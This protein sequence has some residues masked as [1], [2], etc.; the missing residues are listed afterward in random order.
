MNDELL[1]PLSVLALDL[2]IAAAAL[3]DQLA[4]RV[5]IDDLGRSAIDRPTARRLIAEHHATVEARAQARAAAVAE[6]RQATNAPNPTRERV[7]ALQAR[8]RA[9]GVDALSGV[10]LAL[11][12]GGDAKLAAAGRRW[13]DYANAERDGSFGTYHR[14]IPTRAEG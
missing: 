5:L 11:A 13:D 7:R 9:A 6:R 4:D 2:D 10:A 1:V 8:H 12:D 3:A 14:L